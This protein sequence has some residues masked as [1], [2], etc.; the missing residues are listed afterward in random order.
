MHILI[1]IKTFALLEFST[2]TINYLIVLKF[3][4]KMV[5]DDIQT[6]KSAVN[7]FM[8][9]E[10]QKVWLGGICIYSFAKSTVRTH[11]NETPLTT[12]C[13]IFNGQ[14]PYF[15]LILFEV[16]RIQIIL[17]EENSSVLIMNV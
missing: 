16:L 14:L 15:K 9:L 17:F 4:T 5:P 3:I 7:P 2:P 11:V 6:I 12:Y 10:H 8:P 1:H 13:A